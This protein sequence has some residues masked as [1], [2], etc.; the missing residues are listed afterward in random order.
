MADKNVSVITTIVTINKIHYYCMIITNII[1][2]YYRQLLL[3]WPLL[4]VANV[5][6]SHT[7]YWLGRRHYVI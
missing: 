4:L 1:V 7:D 6:L 3:L 2:Y 5:Q